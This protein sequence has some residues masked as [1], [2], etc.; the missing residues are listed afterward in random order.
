MHV[1]HVNQSPIAVSVPF[2]GVF[3]IILGVVLILSI[4][5]L[6]CLLYC[7]CTPV[8]ALFCNCCSGSSSSK[9]ATLT[10]SHQVHTVH[11]QYEASAPPLVDEAYV[12]EPSAPMLPEAAYW[13]GS[14]D[15]SVVVNAVVLPP[16]RQPGREIP[17]PKFH[18]VWAAVLFLINFA[19]VC[20]TAVHVYL[21]S[22][23]DGSESSIAQKFHLGGITVS[24]IFLATLCT[25]AVPFIVGVTWL[26][27]VILHAKT[28][29]DSVLWF[30]VFS[31]AAVAVL[32]LFAGQPIA[33]LLFALCAAVSLWYRFAV[34][35][36]VPFASCVL[37]IACSAIRPHYLSI[38]ILACVLCVCQVAW[39]AI[40][41]VASIEGFSNIGSKQQSEDGS[42][43]PQFQYPGRL[44]VF[45]L[46][47]SLYWGLQVGFAIIE[48]T[49]SGVVACWWFQPARSHVVRGSLFRAM[50]YSF[51]SLCFGSLIVALIM[52]ARGLLRMLR[53]K[54]NRRANNVILACVY[55]AVDYILQLI[56]AAIQYFNKY[57]FCYV[58]A[59]GN[60][61]KSSGRSVMDLFQRRYEFDCNL[62]NSLVTAINQGMDSNYQRQL[63]IECLSGY[64]FGSCF[65]EW[66]RGLLDRSVL[67]SG[68]RKI[69]LLCSLFSAIR[70]HGRVNNRFFA[71]GST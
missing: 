7:I 12:Y 14:D 65:A 21:Q 43:T 59:Y 48:T 61:F 11:Y 3:G 38:M 57:A 68:G 2:L 17:K 32:F 52:A 62:L 55:A 44:I 47:L 35:N 51:G 10:P 6:G 42:Q 23:A 46:L 50:T 29:I 36:R 60:D 33:F 18:D 20:A 39:C 37:D 1:V 66:H 63:D 64:R 15:S 70:R 54:N 28:I 9:P 41:A 8:L 45:V 69:C 22:V 26:S 40:W 49:V 31:N 24:D 13:D 71:F 19:V 27:V 4:C 56:E 5:C 16:L 67:G 30:S 53:G 58:A 34:Q 25:V